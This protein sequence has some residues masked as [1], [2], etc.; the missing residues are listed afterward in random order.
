MKIK[1]KHAARFVSQSIV[2]PITITTGE[3][4]IVKLKFKNV[5]TATWNSSGSRFCLLTP[6]NREIGFQFLRVLIG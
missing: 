2:D 4:A 6:W 3:T 1:T 5:D